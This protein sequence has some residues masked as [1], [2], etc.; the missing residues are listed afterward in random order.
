M[1]PFKFELRWKGFSRCRE[2][3]HACPFTTVSLVEFGHNGKPG[4]KDKKLVHETGIHNAKHSSTH[5]QPGDVIEVPVRFTP[6]SNKTAT[7]ERTGDIH[8]VLDKGHID[9]DGE[10][11]VTI[12]NLDPAA[13]GW[14]KYAEL[15]GTRFEGFCEVYRLRC[16]VQML[17]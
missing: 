4:G 6:P 10:L 16:A 3:W 15:H 14:S 11:I 7:D 12:D 1:I 9:I 13:D 8:F 5:P 2:A 17:P